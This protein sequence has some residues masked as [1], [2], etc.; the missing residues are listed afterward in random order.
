[1]IIG[2]Q[3]VSTTDQVHDLQTDA[4][5][6]A[7]AERIFTDTGSGA[8]RNR[9]ELAICLD[10]I[11]EGDTLICYKLD[12][13]S[14]SLVHLLEL[15]EGLEK[16]GVQFKSLSENIDTTTVSGKM[17]FQIFCV[18][19][20]YERE[21]LRMRVL[22]GLSAARSR[23]RIGGRPPVLKDRKQAM[24]ALIAQGLTSKEICQALGISRAT[25]FRHKAYA[26]EQ[27]SRN[28]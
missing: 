20:N 25:F 9:P 1:M 21:Q 28:R 7:G 11:R 16:R 2:Y 23:G 19:A 12:R 4:L 26:S 8:D 27:Q 17:I 24:N 14:R 3:R 5:R 15:V 6:A 18:L 13:L 22:D 10:Q